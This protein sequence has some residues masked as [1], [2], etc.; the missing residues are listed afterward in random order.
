M[1]NVGFGYL[2]LLLSWCLEIGSLSEPRASVVTR[3]AQWSFLSLPSMVQGLQANKATVFMWVPVMLDPQNWAIEFSLSHLLKLFVISLNTDNSLCTCPKAR[4]ITV[5]LP[6]STAEGSLF[7]NTTVILPQ[8]AAEGSLFS[9]CFQPLPS[10]ER[11][12]SLV[13]FPLSPVFWSRLLV[14]SCNFLKDFATFG[15]NHQSYYT[16]GLC[17]LVYKHTTVLLFLCKFFF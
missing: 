9:S 11:Q 17:P 5:I 1:D 3:K 15:Y 8:S 10:F 4:N 7:S 6:E 14:T 13:T 16:I 2:A 12:S